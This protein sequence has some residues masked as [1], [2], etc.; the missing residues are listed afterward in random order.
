[1]WNLYP[2]G[3][4]LLICK[5]I[6]CTAWNASYLFSFK[7]VTSRVQDG[8][9]SVASISGLLWSPVFV[10]LSLCQNGDSWFSFSG[11][12]QNHRKFKSGNK[13][14]RGGVKASGKARFCW[15]AQQTVFTWAV[16]HA[17]PLC[18]KTLQSTVGFNQQSRLVVNA[19]A[20]KHLN[21]MLY[22]KGVLN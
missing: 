6:W 2:F 1:M 15:R 3:D 12:G 22:V 4:F 8:I 16:M 18:W 7:C 9:F 13:K 19:S 10:M 5:C 21:I 17:P 14:K 20:S 11:S